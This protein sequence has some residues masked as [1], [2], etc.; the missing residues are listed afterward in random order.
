MT[1]CIPTIVLEWI[2]CALSTS[3]SSGGNKSVGFRYCN[4]FSTVPPEGAIDCDTR[5]LLY[6]CPWT[7]IYIPFKF[8][9]FSK[10]IKI[11]FVIRL[12]L[13]HISGKFDFVRV[14]LN[15]D[16]VLLFV[17]K[18]AQIGVPFV[19]R[20]FP[21][22]LKSILKLHKHMVILV[23]L[24]YLGIL[25]LVTSDVLSNFWS[26]HG[27]Q[28]SSFIGF[29]MP[30][31]GHNQDFELLYIQIRS[32]R[33][34]VRVKTCWNLHPTRLRAPVVPFPHRQPIRMLIQSQSHLL[35]SF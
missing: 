19:I 9:F 33:F 7:I 6:F 16:V 4:F 28:C 30:V 27:H 23:D 15:E 29:M 14:V 26:P 5:C 32:P 10:R 17:W 35:F 13:G 2:L 21:F 31:M 11:E 3:L 22:L 34:R 8:L 18:S 12:Y 1:Q 20:I 24:N 25:V